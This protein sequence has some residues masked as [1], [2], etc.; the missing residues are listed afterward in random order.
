MTIKPITN[1]KS[2]NEEIKDQVINFIDFVD[3][4]L[5]INRHNC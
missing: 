2:G 5:G 4:L 3:C 1:Q